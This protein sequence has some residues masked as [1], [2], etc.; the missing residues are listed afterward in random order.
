MKTLNSA[1]VRLTLL[2]LDCL[3]GSDNIMT[4]QMPSID[5]TK[6]EQRPYATFMVRGCKN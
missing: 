1:A 6:Q 4:L 2:S 5:C 3:L